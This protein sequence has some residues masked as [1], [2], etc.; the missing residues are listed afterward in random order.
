MARYTSKP[1]RLYSLNKM[2]GSAESD[3]LFRALMTSNRHYTEKN[4]EGIST[5]QNLSCV[6]RTHLFY[7]VSTR[8]NNFL[9]LSFRSVSLTSFLIIFW[10]VKVKYFAWYDGNFVH[11]WEIAALSLIN[12]FIVSFTKRKSVLSIS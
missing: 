3:G 12:I 9:Y 5:V 8:L 10:F 11:S 6:N 1:I 7:S 2:S 4:R